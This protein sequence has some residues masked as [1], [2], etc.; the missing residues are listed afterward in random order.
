MASNPYPAD[1]D[2]LA[3]AAAHIRPGK[4]WP[5][6]WASLSAMPVLAQDADNANPWHCQTLPSGGWSCR[7]RLAADPAP[8]NTA[9]RQTA[10]AVSTGPA[11]TAGQTPENPYSHWF[12]VPEKLMSEQQKQRCTIGPGC[13]GSY[14]EPPADWP[15]AESPPEQS[16]VMASADR[17]E[18]IGDEVS[19]EGQVVITQGNRRVQADK[20]QLNR[21]TGKL[22][23]E[24]HVEIREPQL[25]IRGAEAELQQDSGTGEIAVAQFI[26]FN[27]GARGSAGKLNRT[28]DQQVQLN[29]VFYT[30]CTPDNEVWAIQASQIDLDNASGFGKAKHARLKIK[31]VPV[32]YSPWFTFPVDDR[33]HTGFLFPSI[34]SS[35]SNSSSGGG[36]DIA[37]PFYLNLAP[38]YDATITP[39]HIAGRGAMAE[40][41]MRHLSKF[42][43][44]D[45]SG[46]QLKNDDITGEDRWLGNIEQ[47]GKL[48]KYFSTNIDYTKVSDDDYFKDLTVSSLD[49]RRETHLTQQAKFNFS[50]EYWRSSLSAVNYQTL[51]PNINKPY[52]KLPQF[53]LEHRPTG[54]SFTPEWIFLTQWTDFDHNDALKDGGN[55]VTGQRAYGEAGVSYPMHWGPGFIIPTT[56][57]RSNSY[58]LDTGDS[59][60]NDSPSTTAPM[61]SLD[62]G[63]I[64]ERP[65]RFGDSNFTQTLEPRLF[66]YY[67]EYKEQQDSPNFDS[68]NL[69]FSY[70]Q[71]YRDIRF[72]SYDRIDDANQSSVG[73]TSR[74]V[75][76]ANG[77]EVVTLNLGQIFY[78]EDRRVLLNDAQLT[79][80]NTASNSPVVGEARY[81]PLDNMWLNSSLL[82]NN[83]EDTIDQGGF[84]Y[85]HQPW[86]NFLYNLGYR[87][88]READN[89]PGED[90]RDLQQSDLS[91]AYAL[92]NRWRLLGRFNYDLENHYSLEDTVGIEYEDCCW[93][94]RL[95]YQ[96]ALEDIIVEPGVTGGL[97]RNY[98]FILEFRLKGLGSMGTKAA[99]L[100]E[101][102]VDGYKTND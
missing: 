99:R 66:Y 50:S 95:L 102:S 19:L 42:G 54:G 94:T 8:I 16:P 29:D 82:W 40:L 38:N 74:F 23:L 34:S 83:R 30:Q 4:F 61:A 13:D 52:Q 24:G 15:N 85:H 1:N 20:A 58:R 41:E 9:K 68:G 17:S 18:I 72:S 33:R 43:S 86:D 59:G 36:V 60:Q 26:D 45:L 21:N 2:W 93:A 51:D 55:W 31:D 35:S 11:Q 7:E 25:L 92:N 96:R 10:P 79:A 81:Q 100:L 73:L 84:S 27:S 97:H 62:I 80:S 64:Y 14:I 39:S 91:F 101:E 49:V 98:A 12:W 90:T 88:G 70:Y 56:K 76:N 67:S 77:R 37:V 78:F 69:A 32:F 22:E 46:A 63:L 3:S 28:G 57:V 71:L 75:D 87:W 6:L 44:L 5:L 47:T 48:G 53:L 65:S 89:V